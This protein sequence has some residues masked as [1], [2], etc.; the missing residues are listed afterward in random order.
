VFAPYLKN[1][2]E[3]AISRAYSNA[4]TE[5]IKC[6]NS[7]GKILD[8]GANYGRIFDEIT[9]LTKLNKDKYYGV[10]WN[11]DC[12]I[13]AQSKGLAI[14]N[15][16][17]NKSI[18]FADEEFV[19]VFGLSVLEHLLN[20]CKFLKESYR[21]IQKGGTLVI[22]T[23]NISTYFTALLILMGEMPSSGPHPDS[24]LLLKRAEIYRVSN[25]F[26]QPDPEIETPEHRH[27]VVFSYRVLG[28]YLRMVGFK[29]VRGC[30]FG[31]YPFPNFMQPILEKV[32][33]YHCHQMVFIA[34]K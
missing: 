34:R 8:C 23:P 4:I 1:L 29:E 28:D 11:C 14:V 32:D 6:I 31:L 25:E 17:L 13:Q 7:G 20:P 5:I 9:S 18:P 27:L 15:G 33:P 26:I 19:C 16:D 24:K 21:V 3:S 10:E 22:L 2:Y 12:V 30:G